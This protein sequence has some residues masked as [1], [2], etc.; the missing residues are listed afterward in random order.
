METDA[1]LGE[2][3]RSLSLIN[4]IIQ[5]GSGWQRGPADPAQAEAEGAASPAGGGTLAHPLPAHLQGNPQI[6]PLQLH[7]AVRGFAAGQVDNLF[8]GGEVTAANVSSKREYL[9]SCV[10]S[11]L[12]P[13]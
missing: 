8:H 13:V 5:N 3:R 12:T 6:R 11:S 2:Q 9:P 10:A 1:K 4:S 7:G